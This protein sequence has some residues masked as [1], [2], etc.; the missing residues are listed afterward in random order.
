MQRGVA[1]R[2]HPGC[3]ASLKAGVAAGVRVLVTTILLAAHTTWAVDSSVHITQ[4]AHTAWRIQ[5]GYFAGAPT[6]IAQTTDGYL[7]IGTASGLFRFD[8]VRFVSWTDLA[9]KKQLESAQVSTLLGARDGSLWIGAAVRFFRWKDNTLSE[10]S[11]G[12]E[13]VSSI[14]ESSNGAIWLTREMQA[15]QVG[16]LC[17][18]QDRGLHC[19]GPRDGI[20]DRYALSL[21][22]DAAGTLWVG[23]VENLIRWKSDS[24]TVWTLKA[25]RH[26]NGLEGFSA[27]AVDRDNSLWVGL[28]YPGA[29]LGLEQFRDGIWKTF[30]SSQLNG[31]R[32][33]VS[34]LF[35]DRD[36]A[37]W[38]GTEDHGIYRIIDGKV[39]HFDSAD[40]LSGDT[41]T[42]LFQ[43]HEGTIWVATS[44]GVDSFR[45]LPIVSISK[46]EGLHSD[47][48][49]SILSAKDG[50]VWIG[51]VGA[52]DFWRNGAVTS[53]LPK[54]GLPGREVTSLLQDNAG[55]LWVGVDDGLFRLEGWKFV[56]VNVSGE[57][58]P[59]TNL[60]S[61]ADGSAWALNA[62]DDLVH[63]KNGQVIDRHALAAKV[64]LTVALAPQG[65][66]WLAGDTL[67]YL[68]HSAVTT[69]S[70]FGPRYGYIRTIAF[71]SDGFVWFG[72]TKGLVGLVDGKLQEM[73][74][75]NGL[76]CGRINALIF[77]QHQSL[78]LYAQCGLVKIEHG[79]LEKWRRHPDGQVKTA[80][81]D[82][83]DGF[84]GGP[85]PF[86]PAATQSSD[87]R[88]W[89]VNSRVVQ[90]INPDHV[91]VNHLPP[92]VH[93][94]Q[95]IA[96]AKSYSLDSVIH[97]PKL[98]R[99]IEIKYSALS[100]VVP[101][102]VFF[103]YK[104]GGY[105]TDWQE[106]GTR[107]SAFYTNLR[108]GTYKFHVVA[109][110]NDGV[111]NESGAAVEF[112]IAPAFYQTIW[113]QVFLGLV[114][115]GL[116][117]LL[118][119]FRLREATAR[120]QARLEDR[121][122]ERGRIAREL[123]DTLIQSVDG[124]ML[125]LQAAMD[126][127]DRERSHQMLE[128]A[129]DRADDAM[130]EGRERVQ[131]LRTEALGAKDLSQALTDYG[132]ER[133]QDHAMQFSVTLVGSPRPLDPIVRDEAFRIGR[134]ALANAFQ[135]S[136]ASK[137][138]LELT[139]NRAE[140]RLRIR[141]DGSGIDPRI[142]E[143]G[144]P[145]HWGLP[146]MRERA[147]R[148][149]AD[150]NIWS[151]PNAGTEIDLTIPAQAA[152]QRRFRILQVFG[153]GSKASRERSQ[154]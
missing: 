124:L 91:S 27:V 154:R 58:G 104:L 135:H 113:F 6:A 11:A 34:K 139:Y 39:D 115:I 40:G 43:D 117:C 102:R 24:S 15:P 80:M 112:V 51:N 56:R 106:A 65:D 137:I 29:G 118:H 103:R 122:E 23:G 70:E 85:T 5:D 28:K 93:I 153:N 62:T 86:R 77:D 20:P 31:S 67:G 69:I 18:V 138:E 88:L 57:P 92:P 37:L 61:G 109:C 99:N 12:D 2:I 81:F 47:A 72:A 21:A 150:L 46:R 73:T 151:R 30:V 68:R 74:T 63:I 119:L 152:Y 42:S 13:V 83:L 76:P 116:I 132:E 101:Q 89:F 55:K 114:G 110:N 53:I 107:R 128:K 9:H 84:Q 45:D 79:E 4:Y 35:V 111:W 94:E 66:L 10:Y 59:L 127:P 134:E 87:G 36:G 60:I 95:A 54:D 19:Y 22:E 78:W 120:I 144:K 75:A 133:A 149:G 148:V 52:L 32:L 123:H 125:Y 90:T 25:L 26:F 16:T 140:I 49:Q 105:D 145:G 71:D 14:V 17:H 1:D 44:K 8:G 143:T 108:P 48:A 141:D 126:E 97:F 146:G 41:V 129:L 50:T 82:V 100:F 3:A 38:V 131:T 136:G 121:L 142:V 64:I 147:N 98:S 7:W 130:L 96:D 33:S